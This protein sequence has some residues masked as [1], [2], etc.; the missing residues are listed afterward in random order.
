MK[1]VWKFLLLSLLVV[2]L[3]VGGTIYYFLNVKTYEVADKEIEEITESDYEIVLPDIDEPTTPSDDSSNSDSKD[4]SSEESKSDSTTTNSNNSKNNSKST[5]TASDNKKE[6]TNSGS[7]SDKNTSENQP[8]P[9]E[10]TVASIKE[11]YRPVFESLESQANAKIDGLVNRAISEYHQKKDSGESI[12]VAYFFQK[13]TTAGKE[14]ES[15]TDD[16]FNYI[17]SSLQDNLKKHGYSPNHAQDF[18]D[19][20][21]SA[22]RARESA[23]LNKA[24][25]AL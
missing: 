21:E 4:Q 18:K 15:N 17:Y 25:E 8:K 13:Y 16:A 7:T 6:E 11:K 23:L 20:Y 10:V 14:L 1:K 2:I 24:R 3:A 9:V 22:K 12:S 19:Q 5:S